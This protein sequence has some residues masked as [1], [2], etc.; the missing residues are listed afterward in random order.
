MLYY[1]NMYSANIIILLRCSLVLP[2][3]LASILSMVPD[4]QIATF[5]RNK[6][7]RHTY[8]YTIKLVVL[9][10]G[11]QLPNFLFI[12]NYIMWKDIFTIVLLIPSHPR[13]VCFSA[14][15]N[16][17]TPP[18]WQTN[19]CKEYPNMALTFTDLRK[20]ST[21]E[22]LGTLPMLLYSSLSYIQ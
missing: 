19:V 5:V 15:G 10:L 18:R 1:P 9:L 11:Q 20:Y 22:M 13:L 6:K 3:C 8:I 7:R 2:Y 21:D 14:M 16:G 4:W 12:Y 17:R